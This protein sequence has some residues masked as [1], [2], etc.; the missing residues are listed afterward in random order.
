MGFDMRY[1]G[2]LMDPDPD[3]GKRITAIPYDIEVAFIDYVRDAKG[4][5]TG[6]QYPSHGLEIFV[7]D[8]SRMMGS[9]GNTKTFQQH[10]WTDKDG[11]FW[12]DPPFDEYKGLRFYRMHDLIAVTRD[13][14]L[15]MR[16]VPVSRFLPVYLDAKRKAAASAE[17]RLASAKRAY[18]SVTSPEAEA[19]HQK[20]I[21]AARSGTNADQ[22]VRRLEKI[23]QRR[24]EDAKAEMTLNPANP[25][26]KW[27]FAPRQDLADAEALA[28]SLTGEGRKA[29][30]CITG[31]TWD[32]QVSDY[33]L[34]ADGTSGC[35]RIVEPNL[36]LFDNTL[37]RTAIQL[38][39]VKG[40]AHCE[41]LLN[42]G[43][44]DMRMLER[45]DAGGCQGTV[46]LADQLDWQKL[47]ALIGK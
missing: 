38:I 1:T 9:A 41:K 35:H 30:A 27:Y 33:Q 25:K 28:S 20:E 10:A 32:A 44:P 45:M 13:G 42:E 43:T 3:F 37:P 17:D 29:P 4:R 36:G 24:I 6:G 12:I 23:R 14:A 31:N 34:V 19:K 22:E 16:P 7:N 47:V 2:T 15:T 46:K 5:P 8:P 40:V 21:A 26:H 18:E 11:Q 39:V